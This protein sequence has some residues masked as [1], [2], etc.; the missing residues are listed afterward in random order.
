MHFNS[1]MCRHKRAKPDVELRCVR[2]TCLKLHKLRIDQPRFSK[3]YQTQP[4]AVKRTK[5]TTI[6][7]WF[8]LRISCCLCMVVSHN[9]QTLD[10]KPLNQPTSL[11]TLYFDIGGTN[12]EAGGCV[13][14]VLQPQVHAVCIHVL[15]APFFGGGPSGGSGL[16]NTS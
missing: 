5:H 16:A 1:T 10:P 3:Q 4:L 6:T 11:C 8:M 9:S 13:E 2:K 14:I 15:T 7:T 12:R